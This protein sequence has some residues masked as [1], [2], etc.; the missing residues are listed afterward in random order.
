LCRHARENEAVMVGAEAQEHEPLFVRIRHLEAE[1][2]G[3]EIGHAI[4]IAAVEA[5]VADLADPDRVGGRFTHC[6]GS[7]HRKHLKLVV[8]SLG[9]AVLQMK[10]WAIIPKASG[11]EEEAI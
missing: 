4:E 3:V 8:L 2:A 10:R 6:A 7:F 9:T 11:G 5:D 1:H